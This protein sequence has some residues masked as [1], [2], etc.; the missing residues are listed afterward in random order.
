MEASFDAMMQSVLRM[1]DVV[2]TPNETISEEEHAALLAAAGEAV[3]RLDDFRLQ[4]GATLIADLLRRVDKIEGYK[5]EVVP[6]EKARTETIKARIRENL[7]QLDVEVDSNRLEQEM[8]FYLEKLDITE[9]LANPLPLFP[10]SGCRRGDARAQTRFHRSGDG[11]R[12]Q[13]DGLEGQREQHPDSRGKDEGRARKNQRAGTQYFITVNP[14]QSLISGLMGK[15]IIFSAPSGSGKTTIVRELLRR[16]P[17]LEFSISATS[18]AP[19]GTERDGVD[20]YFLSPDEFRRAVDEE[21]FVEWEEVYAGTCYGTLRSELDRIWGKGHTILFDVDVLG[22]INLKRIFGADAC[23]VFIMP[24]SIE[25]LERRLELRGTDA[26][27]VIAKRVAKAE[28]ELTK[29]PEFDHVV[30]NDVLDTAVAEVERIV[31]DFLS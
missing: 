31:R 3:A 10:Q 25:E 22:G 8:I 29:A 20:Y 13:Y 28:F 14:K 9:E 15:L 23:S 16:I 17:Q 24:P 12:N 11:A 30:V 1:P 6:Y 2:S 18:R 7:A 21:R 27:E 26:P 4:E 5:E 19:R